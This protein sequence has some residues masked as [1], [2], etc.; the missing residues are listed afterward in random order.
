[1]LSSGGNI[2]ALSVERDLVSVVVAESRGGRWHL[3][4]GTELAGSLDPKDFDS[5]K[6]A[7]GKA[8]DG[9][10]LSSTTEVAVSIGDH[11]A[12]VGLFSFSDFPQSEDDALAIVRLRAKKEFALSDTPVRLDYHVVDPGSPTVVL[13]VAIDEGVATAIEEALGEKGIEV[14]RMGLTSFHLANMVLEDKVSPGGNFSI[15]TIIDGTLTLMI[16]SGGRLDFYRSK[17]FKGGSDGLARDLRMSFVS[18][19]GGA[20]D[21]LA[22]GGEEDLMLFT[23]EIAPDEVK[24]IEGVKT[25]VIRVGDFL[26]LGGASSS[27]AS[28][29]ILRLAAIGACL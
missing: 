18:Y 3:T 9:A 17:S 16:F 27:N 4:G 29:D 25:T 8:I 2:T 24:E 5:L 13:V 11:F 26:E 10:G 28:S 15:A 6:R 19:G 1:M 12:N 22:G 21:E 7:V 14:G 23:G 20:R